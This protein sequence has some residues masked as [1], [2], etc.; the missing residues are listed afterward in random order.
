MKSSLLSLISVLLFSNLFAQNYQ[1]ANR[2]GSNATDAGYDIAVDV[3]GNVYITGIFRGTVDFDPGQDTA[4]LTAAGSGDIFFGKY[5]ANGNY[6]WANSIVSAGN[7]DQGTGIAVDGNGNCYVTGFFNNTADFD[8]DTG[9]FNLTAIG[10]NDIFFAKYDSSGNYLWAKSIGSSTGD[11]SRSIVLDDS[12]NVY[13]TGHF[14]DTADF[15]PGPDTALLAT[16]G[17]ADIFFAKYNSNGNYLWAKSIGSTTGDRS[18]SVAVDDSGNV[19]ITGYFTDTA[20]FDPGIDTAILTAVTVTDIFFGKY[21]S[22]GDYLWAKS[23]G[24]TWYATS[25]SIILNSIGECYITGTFQGTADFDP[26]T[27]TANLT[28]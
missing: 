10:G 25:H 8:P 19:Y 21:D 28:A 20:D 14:T 7:D 1:W 24:A 13:I 27:G 15:D 6:L 16:V 18:R 26:D 11:E 3:S 23:I 17:S 4:Y 9:M 5:D 2:I 22:N 12:G